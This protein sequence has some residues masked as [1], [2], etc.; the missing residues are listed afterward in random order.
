MANAEYVK[1]SLDITNIGSTTV[2]I[3][4]SYERPTDL[5]D[6]LTVEIYGSAETTLTKYTFKRAQ[7]DWTITP[8]YDATTGTVSTSSGSEVTITAQLII[9]QD[10]YFEIKNKG[11]EE[12]TY[13]GDGTMVWEG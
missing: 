2:G 12:Y 8:T 6:N 11:E 5:R 13:G 7:F 1:V 3:S 4:Y 10:F 9:S